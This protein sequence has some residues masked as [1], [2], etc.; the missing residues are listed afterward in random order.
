MVI[1]D[2]PYDN[3]STTWVAVWKMKRAIEMKP[4]SPIGKKVDWHIQS[5]KRK[6]CLQ[7]V[8]F[9]SNIITF[10]VSLNEASNV[11]E[12]ANIHPVLY[13]TGRYALSM[14]LWRN[15]EDVFT[16]RSVEVLR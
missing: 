15:V 11:F 3:T 12:N 10:I 16:L 8:Y 9:A 13:S 4:I 2:A 14:K 7:S 1:K 5:V 6:V